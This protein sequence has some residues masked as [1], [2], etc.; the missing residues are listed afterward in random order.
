MSIWML[1]HRQPVQV[2]SKHQEINRN[3]FYET[4]YVFLDL[5]DELDTE[6]I[7]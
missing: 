6:K 5:P 7:T 2:E 4:F 1:N 3:I